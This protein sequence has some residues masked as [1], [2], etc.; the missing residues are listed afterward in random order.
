MTPP[1][2]SRPVYETGR[3]PGWVI[4]KMKLLRTYFIIKPKMQ[5]YE[6]TDLVHPYRSDFDQN[7]V[8]AKCGPAAYVGGWFY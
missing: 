5:M 7:R 6:F 2:K 1:K 8:G 4:N 3:L